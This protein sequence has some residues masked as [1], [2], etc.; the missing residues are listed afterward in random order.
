VGQRPAGGR[1]RRHVHSREAGCGA[2]A[3]KCRVAAGRNV[4][5]GVVV[6]EG[7]DA[8]GTKRGDG[9]PTERADGVAPERRSGMVVERGRS[10][11]TER[12]GSIAAER[13]SGIGAELRG[14]IAGRL[15]LG[16]RVKAARHRR[17]VGGTPSPGCRCRGR[18]RQRAGGDTSAARRA[19]SAWIGD[20]LTTPRTNH[21]S[22]RSKRNFSS[23][24]GG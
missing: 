16:G 18:R 13:S 15:V 6:G 5:G 12:G 3:S 8:I 2:S 24:K 10:I 7:S 21:A 9:L 23:R 20:R 4:P 1:G 11:A 19:P 14:R 17:R 22:P